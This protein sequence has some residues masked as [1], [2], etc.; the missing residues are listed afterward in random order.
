MSGAAIVA[1]G[2]TGFELEGVLDFD[3]V[4]ELAFEG[5]RLLVGPGPLDLNLA[6]VREAN[7]AAL[8][9]L[10]EWLETARQRKLMLRIHNLPDSLVRLAEL[11][12]L[13]ALLR[14]AGGRA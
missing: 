6:G 9:L 2:E 1:R 3:S 8:A 4:A 7:S 14:L 13:T 12:N 11:S 5:R 10:L